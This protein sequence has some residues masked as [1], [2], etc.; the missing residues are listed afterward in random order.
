[1]RPAATALLLPSILC[2]ALLAGCAGKAPG[3]AGVEGTETDQAL[4]G[5]EPFRTL[6][7]SQS[8]EGIHETV[9]ANGTVNAQD[10]CNAGGCI[11]T[12]DRAMHP[13]DVTDLLP[14]GVPT[15]V[16]VEL[17][18]NPHPLGFGGWDL[19]L[20]APE[21]TIYSRRE[22][23][24]PG[25]IQGQV[26]LRPSG[27]V[28]VV[29]ATYGPGADPVTS[30][31]LRIA[32]DSE[33]HVLLP[34]VPVSVAM[35]AGDTVRAGS[36]GGGE[37]PFLLYGPDDA[38]LGIFDGEHTLAEGAPTGHYVV[39]LPFGGPTGNVSTDSGADTMEALG[40]R[41]ETGPEST[42]PPNGAL[43]A[44]WDVGGVPLGVGVEARSGE[45]L[46]VTQFMASMGFELRLDGPGGYVLDGGEVCGLCLTGGFAFS[47]DSG[48][49]DPSVVP[50][51]Y[52]VHAEAEASAGIRVQPFAIYVER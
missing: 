9:W 21:S 11:L 10:T 7:Y 18:W 4:A 31:T 40:L 2:F 49:G 19:L 24:Q 41:R 12:A 43:D 20:D 29:L 6:R 32:I 48:S 34:G 37:A 13:T 51:R 23:S 52:T 1:M 38:R 39:L 16:T 33:P 8:S 15:L 45:D 50:G 28:A 25:H 46:V 5:A 36:Y 3:A 27:S 26:V 42:V 47:I 35:E 17:Q 44:P 22:V 30:Y 14:Q